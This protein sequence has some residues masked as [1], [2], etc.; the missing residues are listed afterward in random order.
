[1]HSLKKLYNTTYLGI[2][3]V[4][5]ITLTTIGLVFSVLSLTREPYVS[6]E[7]VLYKTRLSSNYWVGFLLFPND[8]FEKPII[9]ALPNKPMYLHL[10]REIFIN[11][12]YSVSSGVLTGTYNLTITLVHPDGWGKVYELYSIS[13]SGNRTIK[14]DIVLNTSQIIEFM[15]HLCKQA[16]IRLTEFDIKVTSILDPVLTIDSYTKKL[17][18]ITHNVTIHVDVSSN[19]LL[20]RGELL[21]SINIE[22]KKSINKPQYILGLPIGLTRIV[23]PLITTVGISCLLGYTLLYIRQRSRDIIK[24][25]ESKYSELIVE[26]KTIRGSTGRVKVLVSNPEELVK[27]ARLL[28]KPILKLVSGEEY[29]YVVIDSETVYTYAIRKKQEKE[30]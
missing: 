5:A 26:S 14:K 11:H 19:R 13:V 27:I 4:T 17:S 9:Q 3:L 7:V 10:V 30:S 25:F 12:T 29:S 6:E 22:E 16:S 24:D 28:E 8:L 18:Q 21:R 23:S 15:N 20:V 2:L 1:M